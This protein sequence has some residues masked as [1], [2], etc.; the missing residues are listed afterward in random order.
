MCSGFAEPFGTPPSAN[1]LEHVRMLT[2]LENERLTRVA[3]GTPMGETMRRY[4]LPAALSTELPDADGAPVRVRLLGED[5]I[6]FRDTDGAVGLVD[7]FCPHRRAPMFFGRNEACGLRCVY[8]G[9]KFDRDGTCVDMPSEPA[10]SLFKTKV[11]IGAY[12]THEAGGLIWAYLGPPAQRPPVPEGELLRAPA[13]HRHV[14]KNIEECN[15]LQALEG[16][17]DSA[18]VTIL[19]NQNIGDRSFLRD[20]AA[21]IPRID[22]EPTDYGMLYTGIRTRG[23]RQHVRVYHYVMPVMQIRG[24][25]I[26]FDPEILTINGHFWVPIDDHHTATYNWMYSDNPA[27]PLT[28]RFIDEAETEIG[29]GPDQFDPA[30]PFHL[31]A[32]LANDFFVDRD[33]QKHRTMTGIPGINTQDIALQVGMGP[34]ADR[35][36]E[37]LGTSDRAI[38]AL[39]RLLL[40]AT[41]VVEAGGAPRGADTSS[42][43]D[44]RGGNHTIEPGEEW[45][46]AL[47]AELAARF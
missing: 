11:T 19:H 14:S 24:Q 44:I 37:H 39:R 42:A 2:P 15:Y 27:I 1:A 3:R 22:V 18:H 28:Q 25:N 38:I 32:Q 35:S 17:F 47:Q 26:A 16:G 20:F 29:R 33:L 8:H 23:G 31:K 5:L 4:W 9:W 12:P 43:R 21:T 13:S 36:R 34:V 30:R 7:A 10:D 6:A 45:H 41:D 40:E 46:E